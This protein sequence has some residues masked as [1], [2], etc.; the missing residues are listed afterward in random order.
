MKNTKLL[1][2]LFT[3][4]LPVVA[5]CKAQSLH[6]ATD[7]TVGSSV[8]TS[9]ASGKVMV[10]DVTLGKKV[11][12]NGSIASDD[13][14]NRFNPGDPI[15]VALQAGPGLAGST[16]KVVWLDANNQ[17]LAEDQKQARHEAYLDFAAKNAATWPKGDYA[18]EVWVGDHKVGGQQFTIA[19]R[20]I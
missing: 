1:T 7:D 6:E 20:A 13:Q 19:D 10:G 16:V 15:Y 8:S 17:K 2:L 5:G 18:V 9:Q 4:A 14:A 3:L 11:L 12:S